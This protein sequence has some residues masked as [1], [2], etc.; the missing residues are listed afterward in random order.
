[1]ENTLSDLITQFEKSNSSH[2]VWQAFL[3]FIAVH[4]FKYATYAYNYAPIDE[5]P[6]LE[7]GKT[8]H[9]RFIHADRTW[10]SSV[11]AEAFE[12][13]R[14]QRYDKNDPM[15]AHTVS[16]SLRS[17]ILSHSLLDPQSDDFEI[18]SRLLKRAEHFGIVSSFGFPLLRGLGRGH[19][20][21]ILHHPGDLDVM[22]EITKQHGE[23]LHLASLYMHMFYRPFERVERATK[24]GIKGRPLEVLQLLNRGMTNKQISERMAISAPTV[25]FHLKELRKSLRVTSTREIL[26]AALNLGLLDD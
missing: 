1:M 2:K 11:P 23:K 5:A 18:H 6:S 24:L 16:G 22:N 9:L 3:D 21:I 4:G 13:Y 14:N 17:I 15:L 19:G 26:P 12:E 7:E 10:I 25:S 20:H 8:S